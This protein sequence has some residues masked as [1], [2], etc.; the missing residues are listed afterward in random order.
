MILR[1]EAQSAYGEVLILGSKV[2]LVRRD[3]INCCKLKL[4]FKLSGKSNL[5]SHNL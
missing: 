5:L 3:R 4:R 1:I 2:G